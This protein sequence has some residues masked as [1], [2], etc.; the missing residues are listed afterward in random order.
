MRHINDMTEEE[1][2][3]DLGINPQEWRE[4]RTGQCPDVVATFPWSWGMHVRDAAKRICANC[5]VEVAVAPSS[6]EVL[7]MCPEAE[8]LCTQCAWWRK[9]SEAEGN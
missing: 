8:I 9:K 2:L 7:D 4:A 3:Q 1:A 5:G 6:L